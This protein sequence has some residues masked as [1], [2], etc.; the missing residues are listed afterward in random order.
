MTEILT[1]FLDDDDD[2]GAGPPAGKRPKEII[3]LVNRRRKK[4]TPHLSNIL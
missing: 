4:R 3:N 2:F 1:D